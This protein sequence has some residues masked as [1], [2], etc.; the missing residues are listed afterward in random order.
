MLALQPLKALFFWYEKQVPK[1]MTY[2]LPSVLRLAKIS[3]SCHCHYIAFLQ[4]FTTVTW[5]FIC[6]SSLSSSTSHLFRWR[7]V[8]Y[9]LATL[10]RFAWWNKYKKKKKNGV[11]RGEEHWM[12]IRL[13][14][15]GMLQ[16]MIT[17]FSDRIF[18]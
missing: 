1:T 13:G 9:R 3:L 15:E 10:N 11:R 16:Q 8:T 2:Y 5:Y 14:L 12:G 17:C 7:W 18:S 4:H 6:S